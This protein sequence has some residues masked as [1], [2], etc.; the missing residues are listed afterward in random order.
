VKDSTHIRVTGKPSTA[1]SSLRL[2]RPASPEA[3]AAA[4]IVPFPSLEAVLERY[5]DQRIEAR[6][7]AFKAALTSGSSADLLDGEASPLGKRRHNEAC[8]RGLIPDA[9]KVHRRWLA[10]RSA[11]LA[12][13]QGTG[14]APASPAPVAAPT[15]VDQG[16][17]EL[18]AMRG[19][20]GMQRH[21]RGRR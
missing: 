19:E 10:P 21:G 7:A 16:E 9:R 5:I 15:A 8:R 11:V 2:V 20:L 1:R 4:Q 13:I 12:Y 3:P 14:K 17:D 6:L 18:E